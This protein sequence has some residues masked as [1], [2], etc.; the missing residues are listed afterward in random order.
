MSS[1]GGAAARFKP[2]SIEI[3]YQYVYMNLRA[4]L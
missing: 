2:A 3:L 1:L 4:A